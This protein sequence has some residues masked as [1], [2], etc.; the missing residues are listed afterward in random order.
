VLDQHSRNHAVPLPCVM[1][2]DIPR[3]RPGPGA[4]AC[5]RARG[6]VHARGKAV[7]NGQR[8]KTDGMTTPPPPRAE[9]RPWV[10]QLF[11]SE[12]ATHRSR[13]MTWRC[14]SVLACAPAS[15]RHGSA[16]RAGPI[17]CPNLSR[18][19]GRSNPF[20]SVSGPLWYFTAQCFPEFAEQ[21]FS[22]LACLKILAREPTCHGPFFC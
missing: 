1:P 17:Q 3:R 18:A 15:T 14:L 12:R 10:S 9:Q 22:V 6:E 2:C 4:P 20:T 13:R 7:H 11:C 5:P 8:L 16:C 21:A 19:M